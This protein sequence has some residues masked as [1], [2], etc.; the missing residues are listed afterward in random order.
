MKFRIRD[1]DRLDIMPSVDPG[2]ILLT[3]TKPDSGGAI[4]SSQAY[5]IQVNS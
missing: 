2:F 3:K 5:V 4:M 1:K